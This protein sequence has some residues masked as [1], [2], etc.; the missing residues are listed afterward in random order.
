MN[1]FDRQIEPAV[2]DVLRSLEIQTLQ[3]NLGLRCNQRCRHCHVSAS[4]ERTE[5]MQWSVMEMVLRSASTI[6]CSLVDLTGGAP[7]LNPNFRRFVRALRMEGHRVQAR[8]NLTALIGSEMEDLPE[9]LA[10][11]EV[12][13]VASLPCYL[14]ENVCYQRGEKVYEESIAALKRLNA[15]GYG[16]DPRLNLDLV[17]NPGGPSLPPEQSALESD[18]RRELGERFGV[19]FSHL[20]TITNI[21]VG[22]FLSEL[23]SQSRECEYLKL[24]RESFNPRTVEGLMCRHQISVGWDGS[25]F[26]CDFNL[27]LG[28]TVDHGAPDHISLFRPSVLEKRRIVTGEHCFGCT[29][30]HGSS[31]GG[32]LV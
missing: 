10:E 18:Y 23:R 27:A 12:Q 28:H 26:D 15:L 30:G 20:L 22:R 17:Y 9:W 5:T 3:V 2:G 13:L 4:P 11:H 7:E 21:P 8:T 1:E 31:C 32:A 29:A 16:S 19:F 25:L 6:Q 24:L 14:E